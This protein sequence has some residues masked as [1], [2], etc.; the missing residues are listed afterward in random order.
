[1][2]LITL[3]KRSD[4]TSVY[5]FLVK[6][7]LEKLV[8]WL[9]SLTL[10]PLQLI[11]QLVSP[12]SLET[13]HKWPFHFSGRKIL[14]HIFKSFQNFTNGPLWYSPWHLGSILLTLQDVLK[15]LEAS[16]IWPNRSSFLKEFLSTIQ[17]TCMM[18]LKTSHKLLKK[19]WFMNK[20]VLTMQNT[21]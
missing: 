18:S 4:L 6:V 1:M 19:S 5:W 16:C 15:W 2:Q 8:N 9:L 13:W 20:N 3:W 7:A 11:S 10:F 21:V 17:N 12:E 14:Q